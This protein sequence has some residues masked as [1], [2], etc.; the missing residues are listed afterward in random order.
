MMNASVPAREPVT[1]A[2]AENLRD[3]L[4][5]V[6]PPANAL[7]RML[8]TQVAQS[9]ER[10]QRAYELED[11]YFK[12]RDMTEIV[13]TKLEEFK[14]LTRYVTDCER[15]WRHALLNL[16]KAQRRR[17]RQTNPVP[18]SQRTMPQP[19]AAVPSPAAVLPSAGAGVSVIPEISEFD[20]RQ[21]LTSTAGPVSP[22]AAA[23]TGAGRFLKENRYPAS[24]N[25]IAVLRASRTT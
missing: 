25:P 18:A 22:D 13:R 11:R 5:Q 21:S 1:P 3:E 17:T 24:S 4:A 10:L 2:P 23:T 14:A 7:E 6:T 20:Q 16:E 19:E 8:L 12:G 15:A 9:W